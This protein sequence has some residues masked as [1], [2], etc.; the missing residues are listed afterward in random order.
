M[1]ISLL[2]IKKTITTILHRYHIVLFVVVI[3]GSLV[4][5]VLLLNNIIVTSSNVNNG[6][7]SSSNSATFDQ[8]TINRIEQLK[9]DT[10]GSTSINF[11]QGRTNPFIE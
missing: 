9:T 5:V 1:N 6:Y 2:G 4:I 8:A 7:T 3:A 11:S 10:Q